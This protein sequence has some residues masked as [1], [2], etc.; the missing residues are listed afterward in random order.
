VFDE[1][2]TEPFAE[3]GAVGEDTEA[4]DSGLNELADVLETA[5]RSCLDGRRVR[6]MKFDWES[7]APSTTRLSTLRENELGDGDAP[8]FDQA[9]LANDAVAAAD[10][11]ADPLAREVLREI[12]RAGFARERDVTGRWTQR[13]RGAE[14]TDVVRQARK[15]GLLTTEYVLECRTTGDQILRLA[16]Q[17]DLDTGG[18]G[19]LIHPPCGRTFKDEA[20]SEGY[21]LTDLGE[22][23]VQKSNWMTVWV[24]ERLRRVGV[25]VESILWNLSESGEEV[26]LLLEFLEEVWIF[27]LKD[28]TFS[29]GDAYPFNYRR[30]RYGAD[31][32]FVI[33]TEEVAPDARR[34]F[35]ELTDQA[36][37]AVQVV[38]PVYIEGL[39][40]VEPELRE[41]VARS[42]ANLAAQQLQ[43]LSVATGYDV[44]RVVE[45]RTSRS[46]G[47]LRAVRAVPSEAAGS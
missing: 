5:L 19:D 29:A 41:H 12:S 6:Y 32:A 4:L 18:H 30:A 35:D 2:Q 22:R 28:R 3:L 26:D 23:L 1:R 16:S 13:N 17:E 44:R 45:Q 27:E 33:T 10:V 31:K 21:G 42:A 9:D 7:P 47:S 36:R 25:P 15:V 24:T 14:V 40:A 43:P 20:V 39:D 38:R 11:L 46:R 37:R 8:A 34:V